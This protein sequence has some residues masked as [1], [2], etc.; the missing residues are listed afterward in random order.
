MLNIEKK[1]KELIKRGI[2]SSTDDKKFSLFDKFKHKQKQL[3]TKLTRKS[4]FDI[5]VY[6]GVID[7]KEKFIEYKDGFVELLALQGYN[8]AGMSHAAIEDILIQYENLIKLYNYPIKLIT[9]YT[10]VETTTQQK[11]YASLASKTQNP[12]HQ[13]ILMENYYEMK[14]FTDNRLNKEFYVFLYADSVQE[15]KE[16]RADFTSYCGSLQFSRITYHKKK[17][18][19]F[20]MNNPT[21][22]ALMDN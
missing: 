17:S 12:I 8:L 22:V 4:T 1:Q 5:L 20:R 7:R 15:L 13:Q 9:I 10:P 18:I 19:F 2:L 3:Q 6:K 16:L 11:Y 21:S 14:W